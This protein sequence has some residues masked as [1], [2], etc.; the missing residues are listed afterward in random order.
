MV[1]IA[2]L[3]ALA[4]GDGSAD[5]PATAGRSVAQVEQ[6]VRVGMIFISGHEDMNP[7]LILSQLDFV[8]GEQ[9]TYRKLR[10]AERRLARLG[11]FVVDPASGVRPQIT[12][13]G[14]GEY[15]DITVHVVERAKSGR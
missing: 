13:D 11:V 7:S 8:P 4:L 6:P 9:I 10:E 2:F 5:A 3:A 15:I 1:P 14:M 12:I